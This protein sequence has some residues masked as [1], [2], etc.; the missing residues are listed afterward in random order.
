MS[1]V[2]RTE[3]KNQAL[4]KKRGAWIFHPLD[5]CRLSLSEL[6][7]Y[8]FRACQ[9]E[10]QQ[11]SPS[12]RQVARAVGMGRDAVA[13][14][15]RELMEAGLLDCNLIPQEPPEGW[16]QKKK[17]IDPAKHWRHGYTSWTKYVPKP[18]CRMSL[19][20]ICCWSYIA[21]CAQSGWTPRSG[22]GASYLAAVLRA[23]RE[24]VQRVLAILKE[25]QLI[26]RRDGSWCPVLVDLDWLADKWDGQKSTESS[27]QKVRWVDLPEGAT[28][29][30][31]TTDSTYAAP[32]A[33]ER[34]PNAL[35]N[36]LFVPL[37]MR[38]GVY[39]LEERQAIVR[40]IL[41]TPGWK[42]NAHVCYLEI[43]QALDFCKTGEE[44]LRVEGW[45]KDHRN[46]EA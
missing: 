45:L 36:D 34:H 42:K 7:V 9:N 39:T 3:R 18:D 29:T 21:H 23:A 37:M 46:G 10:Y 5:G 27:T 28:V 41:A 19:L 8:S 13:R 4:Q 24:S 12:R 20:T 44:W 2:A 1:T 16:F 38:P 30:I 25:S 11:Q 31:L 15:D 33:P 14:A 40:A 32:P 35:C 17:K 26:Q 43:S 22:V 6:V